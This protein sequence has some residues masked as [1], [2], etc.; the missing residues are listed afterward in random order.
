LSMTR[1]TSSRGT[2]AFGAWARGVVV[3]SSRST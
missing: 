3:R 1:V 2:T